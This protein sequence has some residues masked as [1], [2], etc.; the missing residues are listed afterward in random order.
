[1]A[2]WQT[3]IKRVVPRPLLYELLL[4]FPALYRTRSVQYET[5]LASAT[6][7]LLEQID[8]SVGAAGE[9]IECGSARCG[10]SIIIAQHLRQRGIQKKVYAFDSY[11]GFDR[12][13]LA[14]ERTA[15]LTEEGNEAFANTSYPYVVRK[16]QRL[17][18]TGS[19]IPVKGYFEQ[20]LPQVQEPICF[21]L[22]DCDLRES[23]AYCA[24]YLWPLLTPGGR[25][26]FDD[27]TSGNYRGARIGIDQFVESVRTEIREHGLEYRLYS[28]VKG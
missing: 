7:E 26:V 23:I 15:G 20:T 18:Y 2:A 22:I 21:A 10:T 13:E 16:I 24:Q 9:L 14:R 1:M 28:V 4:A 19:V 25:M 5:N 17:G 8:Q 27:Y 6:S 12:A 3:L 11:E